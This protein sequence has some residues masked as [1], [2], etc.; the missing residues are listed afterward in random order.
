MSFFKKLFAKTESESPQTPQPEAG[1]EGPNFPLCHSL[2]ELLVP[3]G[4][5]GHE[6]QLRFAEA[7]GPLPFQ[8]DMQKGKITFGEQYKFPVQILGTFSKSQE[9]FMWAWANVHS[10]IPAQ[11]LKQSNS[12]SH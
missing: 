9:T 10:G 1:R 11:L 5:I 2:E 3:F 4:P 12:S 8:F 7:I 6:K